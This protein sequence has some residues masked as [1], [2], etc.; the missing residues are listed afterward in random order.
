MRTSNPILQKL[1]QQ[2]KLNLWII[3]IF[4]RDHMTKI[5]KY[6]QHHAIT[7]IPSTDPIKEYNTMLLPVPFSL[8]KTQLSLSSSHITHH[9]HSSSYQQIILE[10][11]RERET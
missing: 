6:P 9:H 2:E 11:E 8:K 1:V 3:V 5:P 4:T 7:K 10:R